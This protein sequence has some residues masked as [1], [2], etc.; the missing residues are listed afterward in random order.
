MPLGGLG[1]GILDRQ[2][3]VTSR[4]PYS[5]RSCVPRSWLWRWEDCS[6]DLGHTARRVRRFKSSDG[7]KS[8]NVHEA[9]SREYERNQM[10]ALLQNIQISSQG[11]TINARCI[12]DHQNAP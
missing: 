10:L 11:I 7:E 1:E 12:M 9:C 2:F 3:I 6:V 8:E 5:P 4:G